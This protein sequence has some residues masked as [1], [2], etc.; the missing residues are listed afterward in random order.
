ME[1]FDIRSH[2][3]MPDDLSPTDAREY[4]HSRF[5]GRPVLAADCRSR[6]RPAAS[7]ARGADGSGPMQSGQPGLSL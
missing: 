3:R 5:S 1:R 2:L 4:P 6:P 7:R